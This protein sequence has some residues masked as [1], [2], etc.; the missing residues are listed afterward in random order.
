[1][2]QNALLNDKQTQLLIETIGKNGWC[3]AD[4]GV[5]LDVWSNFPKSPDVL[6]NYLCKDGVDTSGAITMGPVLFM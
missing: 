1:M 6:R 3:S 4:P 2:N 5:Q